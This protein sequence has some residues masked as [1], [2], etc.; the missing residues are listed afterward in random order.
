MINTK[1][2]DFVAGNCFAEAPRSNQAATRAASS[3]PQRSGINPSDDQSRF[4]PLATMTESVGKASLSSGQAFRRYGQ[5]TFVAAATSKALDWLQSP[6][7][8]RILL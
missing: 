5:V 7:V 2:R 3:S 1:I 4:A 8:V 6:G